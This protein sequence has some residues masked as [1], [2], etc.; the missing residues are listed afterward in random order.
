MRDKRAPTRA[1]AQ[2]GDVGDDFA[3]FAGNVAVRAVFHAVFMGIFRRAV[4]TG[5]F[6]RGFFFRAVSIGVFPRRFFRRRR[7]PRP[8]FRQIPRGNPG[9]RARR[10][11]VGFRDRPKRDHSQ[12]RHLKPAARVR[13]Q[14]QVALAEQRDLIQQLQQFRVAR[15]QFRGLAR[16]RA[17]P[18][19]RFRVDLAER[20]VVQRAED[21]VQR[22]GEIHRAQRHRRDRLQ[23]RFRFAVADLRQ[24][25]SGETLLY[26]AQHGAHRGLAHLA[27]A[28]GDALIQQTERVADAA[29]GGARQNQQ[30]GAVMRDR[31]F[32]QD[33]LQQFA[34]AAD[35]HRLQIE[36][37]APRQNG[38]RQFL[39]VGG[40][41]QEFHMLRRLLQSLQ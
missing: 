20:G 1:V 14:R 19:Q 22:R 32:L 11:R 38:R 18:F 17:L 7:P 41:Q 2:F 23:R 10:G 15:R 39:R 28:V 9:G 8:S 16:I 37:D 24:Q 35:F 3:G 12:K 33:F 31:F 34:E 13:R 25:F 26:H 5:A 27:V 36:L 40:R 4:F 6:P 30:R 29:V 21:F